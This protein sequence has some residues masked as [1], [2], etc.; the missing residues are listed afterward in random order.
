MVETEEMEPLLLV[1][2]K[3]ELRA[4]LRKALERARY[5]VDEAPDGTSA[6]QKVRARRY[7]S[8][9][10]PEDQGQDPRAVRSGLARPRHTARSLQRHL[11]QRQGGLDR[12]AEDHCK[13]ALE[14]CDHH[15]LEQ[16]DQRE[17]EGPP[18]VCDD[19]DRAPTPVVHP[20]THHQ[21]GEEEW[22][23]FSSVED[24]HLQWGGLQ[25][26]HRCQWEGQHGH[27]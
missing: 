11:L 20:D 2:D 26:H 22:S 14:R 1:E 27:L 15:S 4:M 9:D 16:R 21:S 25:K 5:E 7:Q 18:Q 17:K 12:R 13:A 8:V 3:N 10:R 6:V 19:Q 24:A 23:E